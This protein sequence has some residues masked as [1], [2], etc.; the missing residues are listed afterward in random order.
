MNRRFKIALSLPIKAWGALQVID[1]PD[2]LEVDGVLELRL[3]IMFEPVRH[4]RANG[5]AWT[6][7]IQ[8]RVT[9]GGLT[10]HH[11]ARCR[12]RGTFGEDVFEMCSK[13]ALKATGD[14]LVQHLLTLHRESLTNRRTWTG[15][16]AGST[17]GP[18]ILQGFNLSSRV[19]QGV[20]TAQ[21]AMCP[22]GLSLYT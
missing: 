14:N 10:S 15:A 17:T 16:E 2:Y 19:W 11:L 8:D 12:E 3:R 13:C 5:D 9:R 20:L 1:L 22:E 6:I 18:W 7:S 21:F 4:D